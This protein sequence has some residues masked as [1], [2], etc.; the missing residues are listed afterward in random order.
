MHTPSPISRQER[1][2][3]NRWAMRYQCGTIDDV[4]DLMQS[5]IAAGRNEED[6]QAYLD[7]RVD[8][9]VLHGQVLTLRG[10]TQDRLLSVTA[11]CGPGTGAL[12]ITSVPPA[13]QPDLCTAL[14]QRLRELG[15]VQPV[16]HNLQA[17]IGPAGQLSIRDA[18]GREQPL[19]V[20]VAVGDGTVEVD[21]HETELLA[22]GALLKR[23]LAPVGTGA[24]RHHVILAD[25]FGSVIHPVSLE[26]PERHTPNNVRTVK[27]MLPGLDEIGTGQV[28]IICGPDTST[29]LGRGTTRYHIKAITW[30]EQLPIALGVRAG[31]IVPP[32]ESPVRWNGAMTLQEH[33]GDVHHGRSFSAGTVRGGEG[34]MARREGTFDGGGA[35]RTT[36][37][38]LL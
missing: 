25:V 10:R 32:A 6:L 9:S 8:V 31:E 14:R 30:V 20:L 4:D 21:A 27:R 33:N 5:M 28:D 7:A 3:L 23:V 12:Q 29:L 26:C 19:D 1:P 36:T 17:R 24:P 11:W 38:L 18:A 15:Q 16:P 35:D 13:K 22:W 34:W 37:C 2:L